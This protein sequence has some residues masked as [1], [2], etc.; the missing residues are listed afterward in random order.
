[1][2][3]PNYVV[4][5]DELYEAI[6]D[7]L[8]DLGYRSIKDIQ[9]VVK[10]K[11]FYK[12]I[13]NKEELQGKVAMR[14]KVDTSIVLTA[15]SF[16]QDPFN[17]GDYWEVWINDDRIFDSIY[18]LKQQDKKHW[19]SIH[20]LN[21]GDEM[22]VVV[23]TKG[24]SN[25][26][27]VWTNVEYIDV[28]DNI[29]EVPPPPPTPPTPPP[30]EVVVTIK[31][32]NE[33]K[34]PLSGA[35]FSLEDKK[36]EEKYLL[37]EKGKGGIHE[38]VVPVGDYVLKEE[39][40]PLG[41]YPIL[42]RDL[43]LKYVDKYEMTIENKIIPRY[44][45][46]VV[47]KIDEEEN[48]L[49]GAVFHLKNM[50]G[51]TFPLTQ[52]NLGEYGAKLL[53]GEYSIEEIE[54]PE[55]YIRD[56]EIK[57]I[58]I[59]EETTTEITFIN[60]EII[61]YGSVNILK[62]DEN[63]V[64]IGG[65]S[66]ELKDKNE[67]IVE[68]TE[69]N[70]G[71]FVGDV[72]VGDFT[73]V[74]TKAPEGYNKDPNKYE[75]VIEE[76]GDSVSFSI[77]NTR[78]YGK[79]DIE[80]TNIF[81]DKLSGAR[82]EVENLVSGEIFYPSKTGVGEFSLELPTGA[83]LVREEEAPN[84][85]L[86]G[87]PKY[88]SIKENEVTSIKFINKSIEEIAK[89]KI[90]KQD[91]KGKFLEGAVFEV[92]DSSGVV[93]IIKKGKGKFE[94]IVKAGEY[95]ILELSAPSGYD[96]YSK[97]IEG[98]INPNTILKVTVPNTKTIPKS[99]ISIFTYNDL[100][101]SIAGEYILINKVSGEVIPLGYN[102][103]LKTFEAYVPKG[104]YIIEQIKP[105][106]GHFPIIKNKKEI[107]VS[108]EDAENEIEKEVFFVNEKYSGRG[109]LNI[110]KVDENGE[111]LFGAEFEATNGEI[112]VRLEN[113]GLGSFSSKLKEGNWKIVETKTPSGYE[114]AE[115]E[116]VITIEEGKTTSLT[117]A[118]KLKLS[119]EGLEDLEFMCDDSFPT[120][121]IDTTFYDWGKPA[122]QF[123]EQEKTP[124]TGKFWE[125]RNSLINIFKDYD[126]S[127]ITE[128]DFHTKL[129]KVMKLRREGMLD[130]SSVTW[131]AFLKWANKNLN[132]L[133]HLQRGG[134]FFTAKTGIVTNFFPSNIKVLEER[135]PD[136]ATEYLSKLPHSTTDWIDY[137]SIV[138]NSGDTITGA[139]A[140][141]VNIPND[142]SI[143]APFTAF[144]NVEP[145][146]L[147][148]QNS[149]SANPYDYIQINNS[150]W[151][152]NVPHTEVDY[153]NYVL[154]EFK[155]GATDEKQGI[156][157]A[158]TL[159]HE[160]GHTVDYYFTPTKGTNLTNMNNEWYD[161]GGWKKSGGDWK[162]KR[163]TKTA[164]QTGGYPKTDDGFEAPVS[165]YG[166][167]SPMEDF[168]ESFAMYIV[169]PR[170]LETFHPKRYV[171]IAKYL[172]ILM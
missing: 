72:R 34:E 134:L 147:L 81:G 153:S 48:P 118:N 7:G 19:K 39:K 33:Y 104:K 55:G 44:G 45:E 59:E 164:L 128:K 35:I 149:Q 86:V 170:F 10:S 64:L 40:E 107:L 12:K 93:N 96:P 58:T 157:L 92:R 15:L 62:T 127:K 101:E 8:G 32:V 152:V 113:T 65:A 1:M 56:E 109:I 57:K 112:F 31:K 135:I 49:D 124:V 66:F 115:E 80:K 22:K 83:Y 160:Y 138:D 63:G 75:G 106:V 133:T 21:A 27:K 121:E 141:D 119:E 162:I 105:P 90:S 84:G 97:V 151:G 13:D 26:R 89:I 70:D 28:L 82:F 67:E 20:A 137:N 123:F 23:I 108:Q 37:T 16:S 29:E 41:Y 103:D 150:F 161:I 136:K 125:D 79:L 146:A 156:I 144:V 2:T 140:L 126:S 87:K 69:I 159:I 114:Q 43:Y 145:E 78:T 154:D 143:L 46:L 61:K 94:S 99:L 9:G 14:W 71:M 100:G 24:G 171:Y 132:C 111:E 77:E 6:R 52:T 53:V 166:C 85:Y 5:W 102:E 91:D 155:Y 129:F 122:K 98:D 110:N 142:T 168:A 172:S 4:N 3:M 68:L 120:K 25:V 130:I 60:K 148:F 42:P 158:D 165:D 18:T 74:E 116:Y 95:S 163:K 47:T 73:L 17:Q 169:N 131:Q 167:S 139:T 76:E 51:E 88:C 30:T 54:P 38:G 50:R 117:I 36:T 11:G